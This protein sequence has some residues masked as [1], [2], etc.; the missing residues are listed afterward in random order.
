MSLCRFIYA[1]LYNTNEIHRELASTPQQATNIAIEEKRSVLRPAP[2]C[3]WW[4]YVWSQQ[5]Q[6][7]VGD[8]GKVPVGSL[9]LNIDSPP[10]SK[11]TRCQKF[12]GDI[13]FLKDPPHPNLKPI[14]LLHCPPF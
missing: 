9:R 8:D 13:F 6:V 7:R 5:S 3:P 14:V 12:D 10:R 4:P 1:H 2:A 11:V